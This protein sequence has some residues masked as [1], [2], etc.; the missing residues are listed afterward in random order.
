ML[1]VDD[2]STH[3][4]Y[5]FFFFLP[6]VQP[7]QTPTS[8]LISGLFRLLVMQGLKL[9]QWLS[10]KES[11]CNAGNMETCVSS[12]GHKG[13]LEKEMVPCSSNLAQKIPEDRGAWRATVHGVTKES[14]KTELLNTTTKYIYIYTH[15][16][17]VLSSEM[18]LILELS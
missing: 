16:H 7:R 14:N 18:I 3:S 10:N 17:M 11:S 6:E 4:V 5:A 13:H 15:T 9:S 8:L 2:F 12:L 1:L